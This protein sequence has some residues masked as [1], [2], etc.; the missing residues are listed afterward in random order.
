MH[1]LWV[2]RQSLSPLLP[3]GGV[4]VTQG[5]LIGVDLGLKRV[6]VA[7]SDEEG[8]FAHPLAV[9]P[10]TNQDNVVEELILLARSNGASGFVIGLPKNMDGSLGESARRA[11]KFCRKLQ[12]KSEMPCILMDERLTTS[13]AE[14]EMIG[15]GMSR[16]KRRL[17]V[18]QAAS[19]LI[20]ENYLQKVRNLADGKKNE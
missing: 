1:A 12:A 8:L 18:D 6:G 7:I 5:R 11:L 15:L 4:R 9:I 17:R 13:Q 19:V 16:R 14:R 3:E 2:L 10:Y 20:L